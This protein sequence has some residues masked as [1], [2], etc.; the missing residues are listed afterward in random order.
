MLLSFLIA[1]I[2]AAGTCLIAAQIAAA[3][4]GNGA[5][6]LATRSLI[7]PLA[8][9][10]VAWFIIGSS[11]VAL[12]LLA[13]GFADYLAVIAPSVGGAARPV[14]AIAVTL[15]F[16]LINS[17]GA[18]A[19]VVVQSAMVI[20]LVL[21]LLLFTF[22]AMPNVNMS[23]FTPFASKGV[24][25]IATAV[26][27]AFF[28]FLGFTLIVEVSG[29]VE[30]PA[31]TLPRALAISYVVILF[32]YTG[33]AAGVVGILPP[34]RMAGNAAPVA[35]AAAL[36]MPG[37]LA[38]SIAVSALLA[39]ATSVN[40]VL[41]LVSRDL[42]ELGHEGIVPSWLGG[43]VDKA[44]VSSIWT[45][46]LIS[47]GAI[48]VSA[49]ITRYAVATVLGYMVAQ[50]VIAL[51]AL[52]LPPSRDLPISPSLA[53]IAGWLTFV[54]AILFFL[55]AGMNDAAPVIAVVGYGVLGAVI[56]A[57]RGKGAVSPASAETPKQD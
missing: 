46:A 27:P 6:V 29:D 14:T 7:S 5:N 26:I 1:S 19:A 8:G 54:S 31:R 53:R 34:D 22:I 11:I 57:F 52:R 37:W 43:K 17:L 35:E 48:A 50:A 56:Y 20:W 25:A 21:I 2:P 30:R 15:L 10:V 51:A 47:C 3:F 23:H 41:L 16:A 13:L 40:G 45:V 42:A 4:P 39:A 18:R 33:V 38:G 9:F 36:I 24:A 28:A 32:A 12:A 49:S 55:L 44:P